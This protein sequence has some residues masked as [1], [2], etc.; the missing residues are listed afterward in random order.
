M[1]C[2]DDASVECAKTNGVV[3][4]GD[5]GSAGIVINVEAKVVSRNLLEATLVV[6][7]SE[8]EYWEA[9]NDVLAHPLF[10]RTMVMKPLEAWARL[11]GAEAPAQDIS[12]T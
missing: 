4:E 9:A 3:V 6:A 11:V 7:S 2:V 12:V 5:D 8:E 10:R 1:S